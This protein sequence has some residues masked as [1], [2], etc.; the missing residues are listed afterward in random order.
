[1]SK[2]WHIIAEM[3][4]EGAEPNTPPTREYYAVASSDQVKAVQIL[5]N[6]RSLFEANLT[7]MGEASPD[8]IAKFEMK[9]GEI[10]LI[11]TYS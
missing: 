4:R 7:V 10:F 11:G 9:E 1:M 6:R 5:Q 3:N 8:F 2:V